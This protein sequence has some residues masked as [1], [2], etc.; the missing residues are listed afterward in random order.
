MKTRKQ[1][2]FNVCICSLLLTTI[3]LSTL[4]IGLNLVHDPE[5]FLATWSFEGTSRRSAHYIAVGQPGVALKV[6]GA[7][8]F[9]KDGSAKYLSGPSVEISN[10]LVQE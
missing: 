7:R 4:R 8:S 6:V 1:V 2:I 3:L 5:G 10:R 9:S